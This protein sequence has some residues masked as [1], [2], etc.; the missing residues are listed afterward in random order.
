MALVPFKRPD[1]DPDH[2]REDE[3]DDHA[4]RA[5]KMSFL[6]H[7]DE[8]RR[9]IV[10]SL[11]A[12]VIGFV[13]CLFFIDPIY[14]FIMRPMQAGLEP[15]IRLQ[16]IEP[17]EGF[18]IKI[19]MAALAGLLLATP[20]IMTQVWLFI[21]PGLYAKERKLA[22]PFVLLSSICFL[23]GAAFSHIQ[24]FPWMWRFFAGF[25]TDLTVFVPR[26]GPA[27]GLYVK[28]LLTFGLV[29]Q[30]PALVLIL[31][32]L[33]LVTAKFLWRNLKYAILIMFIV[34]AVLSPGTDP[35]GQLLLAGPMILLYLISIVLAWLFGKKR[36]PVTEP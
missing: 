19:K 21:S 36:Q 16:Y 1:D 2:D 6:D 22:V 35:I 5:G 32:R 20:A 27:F 30:M 26:V 34:G 15:G 33:G 24:A 28:M 3:D 13:L 31:S 11:V 10:F 7:L 12:L 17:T 4:G 9:R 23:G 14:E 25:T 8:L 18:M 29:F